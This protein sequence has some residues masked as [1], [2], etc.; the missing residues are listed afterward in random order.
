MKIETLPVT[1]RSP[2][3][4][5]GFLAGLVWADTRKA[6]R[7]AWRA[8]AYGSVVPD[9]H[10]TLPEIDALVRRPEILNAVA[11]VIG[12][13]IAVEGGFLMCKQP[14]AD[15]PVPWHQDGISD[16]IELDPLRSVTLWAA[17]TE[18][19]VDAGALQ[20]IPGSWQ[21]GYLPYR[22]EQTPGDG[23]G[24]ALTTDVP[25]GSSEPV[26]VPV[27]A[28]QALLMD[29]R[30]LHRSGSNTAGWPRIGL[31]VRYVAPG[32]VT[33]RDGQPPAGLTP[34]AGASW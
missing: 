5:E 10:V 17:L 25:P 8:G 13:E 26:H 21:H 19:T 33:R 28:G 30:L 23:R 15:F 2:L 11:K 6:G 3:G 27:P 14:G 4:H 7:L 9:P 18:A 29:V 24:R 31:N 22:R 32:A 34:I 1:G 12:P 20:V 16:R